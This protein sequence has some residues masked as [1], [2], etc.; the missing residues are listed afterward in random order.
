MFAMVAAGCCVGEGGCVAGLM[1]ACIGMCVILIS[2][3]A[4]CLQIVQI[5]FAWKYAFPSAPVAAP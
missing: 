2:G 3:I 4:T 1:A 5:V